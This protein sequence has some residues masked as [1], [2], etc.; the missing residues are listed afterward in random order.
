[1]VTKSSKNRSQKWPNHLTMLN[2]GCRFKM[3]HKYFIWITIKSHLKCLEQILAV[4]Q[5]LRLFPQ[6]FSHW[7]LVRV[8]PGKRWYLTEPPLVRLW[9]LLQPTTAHWGI[10]SLAQIGDLHHLRTRA[11]EPHWFIVCCRQDGER[12]GDYN[13]AHL[14]CKVR[15]T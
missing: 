13:N 3:W 15:L 1:M 14:R 8:S 11:E 2:T 4:E 6:A 10:L 9:V 12:T 7:F 5:L